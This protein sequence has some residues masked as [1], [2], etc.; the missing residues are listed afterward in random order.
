MNYDNM[1]LGS[2]TVNQYNH[3]KSN[4]IQ[5]NNLVNMMLQIIGIYAEKENYKNGLNHELAL[6]F[7]SKLNENRIESPQINENNIIKPNFKKSNDFP[8]SV[9]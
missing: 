5:S 2:F 9:A 6:E 7:L 3:L 8:K 1:L 4:L